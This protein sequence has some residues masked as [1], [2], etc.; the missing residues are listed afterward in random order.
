MAIDFPDFWRDFI[1]GSLVLLGKLP[2]FA[3]PRNL[4]DFVVYSFPARLLDLGDRLI[5]FGI[6]WLISAYQLYLRRIS[7][8]MPFVLGTSILVACGILTIVTATV[9]F[10]RQI[11]NRYP[12]HV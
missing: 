8:G 12:L 5:C 9:F 10:S 7:A 3:Y 1:R 2:P 11:K 6:E 4:I